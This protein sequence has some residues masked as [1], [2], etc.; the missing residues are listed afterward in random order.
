MR[1]LVLSGGGSKG[2]FQVGVL[3]KW[4]YEDGVDYDIITGTSVGAING[5]YLCQFPVGMP[6]TAW[7][8]LNG[9]W[10][11]AST[12]KIRKSWFPFGVIS[13]LWKRSVYDSSPLIKW[14]NSGLDPNKVATSGKKL[15]VVS[16]SLNTGNVHIA[17][18]TDP[19]IAKRVA[20]SAAF[21]VML[22]PIE[23]NGELWTDGGVRSITPLGEAIRAGATEIDVIMCSSRKLFTTFNAKDSAAIPGYLERSIDIMSQQILIDDLKSCELKNHLSRTGFGHYKD[24]TLRVIEPLVPEL[25]SNSL[26][27][28]QS[29]I[30]RMMEIGY[31]TASGT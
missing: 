23:I 4:M 11:S 28:S 18:E 29:S 27:F 7:E 19:N 12:N 14:I 16:V 10:K 5:S 31:K 20:A 1:A 8:S 9:L 13:S 24:I 30:T 6:K 22:L 3:K 15:R 2:A 21:P 17:S 26:D 25:T